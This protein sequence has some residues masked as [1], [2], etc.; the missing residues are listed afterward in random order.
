MK[1]ILILMFF[2]VFSWAW[3]KAIW[4]WKEKTQDFLSNPYK[5]SRVPQF[6]LDAGHPWIIENR[7]KLEQLPD[8]ES[9]L[10]FSFQ[11]SAVDSSRVEGM[12]EKKG[13]EIPHN[14]FDH[15]EI[16]NNRWEI[17]RPGW[18]NA[19]MRMREIN[20]CPAA[21]SQVKTFKTRV[22]V[23]DSE[24]DDLAK[25]MLEPSRPPQEL[26]GLFADVL[27]NMTSLETLKWSIPPPYVHYFQ[28]HFVDRGL[29]LPSVKTL[30]I[31]G[32]AHFLVPMC[33]NIT[34]LEY[35]GRTT[36][37]RHTS[38]SED[39]ESLLLQATMFAPNLTRFGMTASWAWD[40]SKLQELVSYMPGLTTLY[41]RGGLS[42]QHR[43]PGYDGPSGSR[44][45]VS[46]LK[47]LT[48]LELPPAYS[49]DLGWDGGPGCGNF[50]FGPGGRD[51][52]RQVYREGLETTEA[53][54]AIVVEALP[55]LTNFSIGDS[56]A[57]ITRYENGT[58]WAS[59]PWTGRL[60]EWVMEALPG[61]PDGPDW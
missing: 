18:P 38:G 9:Y 34:E 58:L 3:Q 46:S 48:Q 26:L 55:R 16:N 44:L 36:G 54:A 21:L 47:N 29:V 24:Y 27:G 33:S 40:D 10:C 35:G 5:Q 49:L 15:L 13:L 56:Q 39:S 59:F 14:L 7:E 37:E 12:A 2:P 28:E 31:S 57:N 45:R 43:Y 17:N 50:Y 1:P 30:E 11:E 51:F 60:D 53:A 22:Y 6:M 32:R 19:L 4:E 25:K 41:L 61:G 23:Y 52:E 20:R 8:V 42:S